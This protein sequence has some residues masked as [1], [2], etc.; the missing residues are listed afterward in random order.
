LVAFFR[1]D[2]AGAFVWFTFVWFFCGDGVGAGC[3]AA[4][5]R[6]ALVWFVLVWFLAGPGAGAGAGAGAGLGAAALGRGAGAGRGPGLAGQA[7]TVHA[8]LTVALSAAAH[9]LPPPEAA[10]VIANVATW[11]PAPHVLEHAPHAP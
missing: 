11:A 8:R 9:A 3:G 7:L 5:G 1:S 10:L 2:G 4:A 6:S